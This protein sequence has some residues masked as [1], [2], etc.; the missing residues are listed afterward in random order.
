MFLS[1]INC[2][3]TEQQC[4]EA[5][6]NVHIQPD[7]GSKA[8]NSIIL[9]HFYSHLVPHSMQT[10]NGHCDSVARIRVGRKWTHHEL[11]PNATV[12][13]V[14]KLSLGPENSMQSHRSSMDVL[15]PDTL[16]ASKKNIWSS[17]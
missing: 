2:D 15:F 17:C 12:T 6:L 1:T 4:V 7:L 16:Q 5:H 11:Y 14:L 3:N 10:T 9:Q 8:I 13:F